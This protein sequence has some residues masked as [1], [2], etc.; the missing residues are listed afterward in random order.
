MTTAIITG[1]TGFLGSHFLLNFIESHISHAYAVVRGS[2]DLDRRNR[3]R[4]ALEIANLSYLRRRNVDNIIAR[5]D[6]VEGDIRLPFLG[7]DAA[8]LTQ[9]ASGEVGELWHFA[10]SLN[11]EERRRTEIEE[12]NVAGT[13]NVIGLASNVGAAR[14][15]HCSTAYTCGMAEGSI[16]AEYHSPNR[17]FANAYEQSK[18]LGEELLRKH[19][20]ETGMLVTILRPSVVIGNSETK[21]PAGTESGLYG[22]L[23]EIQKI[24][25]LLANEFAK[26]RIW[27]SRSARVNYV[28]VDEAMRQI[29][30]IISAPL[31]TD[32]GASGPSI[33]HLVSASCPTNGDIFEAVCAELNLP[34]LA[35]GD[36]PDFEM[37]G[38]EELLDH[39]VDF[40]KSYFR[41]H[42]EFIPSVPNSMTISSSEM[43]LYIREAVMALNRT[44]ISSMF[45]LNSIPV[46]DGVTLNTYR[47]RSTHDRTILICNAVGM[48]VEIV[49]NL[50]RELADSANVVTWE[51]RGL[52]SPQSNGCLVDFDASIERQVQDAVEVLEA[53][54]VTQ[55]ALVG[56]CSG[57]R[58]AL[59]LVERCPDTV[60]GIVLMNGGYNFDN[61]PRTQ[62][63]INIANSMPKIASDPRYAEIF[64]KSIFAQPQDWRDNNGRPG[65]SGD[66]LRSA[67][68]DE[69]YLASLPF[70]SP[71]NL[72]RYARLTTPYIRSQTYISPRLKDIPTLVL[73]GD[74]DT[75][76]SEESSREFSR[77]APLTTF[78][79]IPGA[80]HYALFWD[81][82]F[83]SAAAGFI[84]ALANA[85]VAR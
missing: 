84:A 63:E 74:A 81:N 48:P 50:A 69:V 25:P 76:A 7:L 34:G 60:T 6:V 10:A 66:L 59:E 2:S 56:W 12:A 80:D 23:R 38:L 13:E 19:S 67:A 72:Y 44:K 77:R 18:C 32:D 79:S 55:A 14:L 41:T 3:L 15:Y 26:V 17:S 21:K 37:N 58:L 82:R 85:E 9:I 49:E 57:A 54:G 73:T 65:S 64:H 83:I 62:F 35:I 45:E 22:F 28:P 39:R 33:H 68:A 30:E 5:I 46:S 36:S 61:V 24:Q 8:T 75:T 31:T 53:F 42:R 27:V 29:G 4:V 52:P 16:H 71:E 40:Y 1:G 20:Q 43:R 51:S 11:Y 47:T 78:T 70:H